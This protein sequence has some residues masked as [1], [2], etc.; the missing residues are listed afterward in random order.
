[1]QENAGK[2]GEN[3]GGGGE[4]EKFWENAREKMG[5]NAVSSNK[6]SS[7]QN[8]ALHDAFNSNGVRMDEHTW[9]TTAKIQAESKKKS[10]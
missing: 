5:E 3:A 7:L 6:I 8:L 2:C 1:M 10:R 9:Y 4:S